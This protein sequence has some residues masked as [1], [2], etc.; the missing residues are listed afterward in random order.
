M[1]WADFSLA[2]VPQIPRGAYQHI[3]NGTKIYSQG[4]HLLASFYIFSILVVILLRVTREVPVL[5][6]GQ[7][8]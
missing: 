3:P 2:E 7:S 6:F 5:A 4:V 8:L 1:S